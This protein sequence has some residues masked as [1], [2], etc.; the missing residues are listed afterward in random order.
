MFDCKFVWIVILLDWSGHL[1][2]LFPLPF[3]RYNSFSD[4]ELVI[5]RD[6]RIWLSSVFIKRR[7]FGW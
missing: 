3:I 1:L 4:R 6:G 2:L 5:R 7:F